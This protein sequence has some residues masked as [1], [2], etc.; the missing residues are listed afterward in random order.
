MANNNQTQPDIIEA[1]AEA[2]KAKKAKKPGKNSI[3]NRI[4]VINGQV[5]TDM[6]SMK[7]AKKAAK[8]LATTD[9]VV[10]V[11]ACEGTLSVALPIEL[12]TPVATTEET[13]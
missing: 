3:K 13:K 6:V 10:Q 11:Y 5:A 9:A 8:Q 1:L 12:V 4:L 7:Q 2:L